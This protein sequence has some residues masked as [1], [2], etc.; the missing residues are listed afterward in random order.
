MVVPHGPGARARPR[1][2]RRLPP[3]V[4]EPRTSW[5][6]VPG[7]SF[8]MYPDAVAHLG[9]RHDE[10]TH[11]LAMRLRR[12]VTVRG[13]VIGPDGKPIAGAF[14]FGRSYAPYEE[15]RFPF[16]PFNGPAPRIAVRDGRFEIP[17]CDP[18]KPSTFYFLDVNHQLGATVEISGRSAATGP[19]TVPAPAMRL[20][21]GPLQGPRRQADRRITG[22]RVR[23]GNMILDHHTG[24]RPC[25][26]RQEYRP[27][28]RRRRIPGQPGSAIGTTTSA[29]APTAAS[30]SSA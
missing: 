13:R 16:V 21:P 2:H 1:A 3:R 20:G 17:G 24:P 19:V 23:P 22:R 26:G 11:D 9:I 18:E 28:S 12:G 10:T 8:P 14:A 4:D 29:P 6:A 27:D 7:P 25:G 30:R 5:G 15:H